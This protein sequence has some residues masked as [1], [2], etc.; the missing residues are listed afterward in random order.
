MNVAVSP[1][2]HA[3]PVA[4]RPAEPTSGEI[5]RQ[6]FRI[7][8]LRLLAA[9]E[10]ATE[11]IE[12]PPVY[13]LPQTPEA[14]LGLVNLHGRLV[15]VFDLGAALAAAPDPR[16]RRL[17][18]VLGRDDDAAALVVDDLPRRLRLSQSER[19]SAPA[20]PAAIAAAVSACYVRD[21][22]TWIDFDFQKLFTALAAN[23]V[24][25]PGM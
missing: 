10:V 12:L 23:A 22:A 21:G 20:L 5:V 8:E 1:T 15:P 11:L 16:S 6:A 13:R 25:H 7:G 24:T 18:L 17:M 2:H 3:S 14:M 4:S 9:F 19:T